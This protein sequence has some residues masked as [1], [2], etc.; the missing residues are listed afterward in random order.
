LIDDE[1][2]EWTDEQ[3][4]SAIP[5]SALPADL[6]DLLSEPRVVV[7]DSETGAGQTAA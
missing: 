1:N 6:Q 4:A 7:P 2:P 5:F 3:F